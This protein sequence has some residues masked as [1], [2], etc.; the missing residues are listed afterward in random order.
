MSDN[1]VKVA[2]FKS[3]GISI[4]LESDGEDYILTVT[5]SFVDELEAYQCFTHEVERRMETEL[6]VKL[7]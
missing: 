5:D 3:E 4:V 7:D 2:E 1:K 6:G